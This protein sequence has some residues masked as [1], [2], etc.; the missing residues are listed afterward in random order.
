MPRRALA[1]CAVALLTALSLIATPAATAAPVDITSAPPLTWGFKA[2]WRA[3]VPAPAVS[4]G[5]ATI[6]SP[7]PG[8]YQTT[9][10]FASGTYDADTATTV[11][12][13]TGSAHW[14]KY[15]YPDNPSIAAV[16]AGYT[17]PLDINLL[18]VTVSDPT[19]TIGP[20]GASVSRMR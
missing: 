20:D 19:V 1:T 13:Y 17:G 3:Y 15:F 18:D 7:G 4:G 10:T 5:A 6:A 16:P 12:R 11:L 9:W 8:G 2:S 14:T